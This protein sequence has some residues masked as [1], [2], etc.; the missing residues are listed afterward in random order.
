MN[1]MIVP[2]DLPPL[3]SLSLDLFSRYQSMS[4]EERKLFRVLYRAVFN[5]LS[6]VSSLA[7]SGALSYFF[8]LR[9]LIDKFGL[10]P[11]DLC[12]LSKCWV[13]SGGGRTAFIRTNRF[14]S[15][16]RN[17][18]VHFMSRGYTSG[19]H[20]NPLQPYSKRS[21]RPIW[22]SLTP[23]GVQLYREIN[24]AFLSGVLAFHLNDV[25]GSNRKAPPIKVR[26]LNT[27]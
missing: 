14:T 18:I 1:N 2:V 12:V 26:P 20:F 15:N 27:I 21:L 7:S 3:P 4:E 24:K 25:T 10:L 9:P 23:S 13:L 11:M 8:V 6:P 17:R 16:E 5:H 22:L 19:S